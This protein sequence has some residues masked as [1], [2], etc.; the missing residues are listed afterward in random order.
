MLNVSRA[1]VACQQPGERAEQRF[2]PCAPCRRCLRSAPRHRRREGAVVRRSGAFF[3]DGCAREHD[4]FRDPVESAA[5]GRSGAERARVRGA[6]HR[7][8]QTSQDPCCTSAVRST[9]RARSSQLVL[10]RRWSDKLP[11]RLPIK[12]SPEPAI[13]RFSPRSNEGGTGDSSSPYQSGSFSNFESA[14][15]RQPR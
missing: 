11:A 4:R 15:R 10:Q 1:P 9:S 3:A 2:T 14:V 8:I 12:Y 5:V 7:T 13:E 6:R